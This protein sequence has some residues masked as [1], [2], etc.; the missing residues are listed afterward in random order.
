[1]TVK[2]SSLQPSLTISTSNFV[3]SLS[4]API[5]FTATGKCSRVKVGSTYML[6]IGTWGTCTL[7][8][9]QSATSSYASARVTKTL[10]ITNTS[11]ARTTVISGAPT[12][13]ATVLRSSTGNFPS[14]NRSTR[15]WTIDK[16]TQDISWLVDYLRS[17]GWTVLRVLN[18]KSST[19]TDAWF[20]KSG[21]DGHVEQHFPYISGKQVTHIILTIGDQ[22]APRKCPYRT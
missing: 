7:V 18:D 2:L 20:V 6:K 4:T 13:S 3:W 10:P 12:P 22:C 5:S 9:S 11:T 16:K 17:S 19:P 14:E 15:S 1:M 8:V 21:V